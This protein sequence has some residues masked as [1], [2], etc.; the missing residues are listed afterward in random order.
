MQKYRFDN[1][2]E[3]V[4]KYDKNQEAYIYVGSYYSYGITKQM[5]YQQA[6]RKIES[7]KR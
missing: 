4:Y 2:Y 7:E 6:V 5:N 1:A 3:S